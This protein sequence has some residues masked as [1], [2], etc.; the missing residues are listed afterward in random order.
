LRCCAMCWQ[1]GKARSLLPRQFSLARQ[2]AA[3]PSQPEIRRTS[4]SAAP[5]RHAS[6]QVR[7][8]RCGLKPAANSDAVTDRS[9]EWALTRSAPTCSIGLHTTSDVAP[10]NDGCEMDTDERLPYEGGYTAARCA[11]A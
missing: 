3:A 5:R 9:H 8:S 1:R 4:H 11:T 7:H 6:T 2:T 10:F